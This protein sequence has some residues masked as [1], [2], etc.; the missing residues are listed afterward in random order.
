MNEAH[1]AVQAQPAH[2]ARCATPLEDGDIRCAVCALSSPRRA[3]ALA[4]AVAQVH[5]CTECG[6][7]VAYVAEVQ[8]PRCGFC[9]AVMRVE[10][11]T[12]PIE[13]TEWIASFA[14][15]PDQAA[16][17]LAR[18]QKTLGFFKPSDLAERSKIDGLW[19]IWWAAWIVNAHALVSW[20]ADSNAGTGRSAWAPH[21]GQNVLDF[22]NLVI[23][24]SRG[25]RHDECARLVPYYDLRSLHR[26]PHGPQ[27]AVMESFE[28]QRSAARRHVVDAILATATQRLQQGT[29]PGSRF[30][31]VHA[32]ALLQSLETSRVVLPAY[33]LAYRYRGKLYRVVI[34][35][36][37]VRCLFGDAPTSILKVLLVVFGVTFGLLLLLTLFLLIATSS[38]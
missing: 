26:E 2:C 13:H 11:P 31:K 3:Q 17:A 24:A 16:A 27:G 9:R 29:I 32:T 5:R 8:A 12:D 34:H 15:P 1:P 21:A 22:R 19:P 18:W 28:A 23:A 10:T 6:A 7:A 30:R 33:V 36:Q 38:K 14:T 4:R 35:G 25:L 20:S 37:D